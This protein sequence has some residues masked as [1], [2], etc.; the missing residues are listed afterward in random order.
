MGESTGYELDD[1]EWE[2]L[3][4][5]IKYGYGRFKI[6]DTTFFRCGMTDETIVLTLEQFREKATDYDG[7]L[8]FVK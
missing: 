7:G 5:Y 6:Y 4:T 8:R 3:N 1:F 2:I